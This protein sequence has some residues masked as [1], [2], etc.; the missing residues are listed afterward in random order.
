MYYKLYASNH[1]SSKTEIF[2]YKHKFS[3]L[4]IKF[5]FEITVFIDAFIVPSINSKFLRSE[6]EKHP[7]TITFT[8]I[9]EL[10]SIAKIT[11]FN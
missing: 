1:Y 3:E 6:A 10:S 4:R 7:H 5:S 11:D 9:R 8:F 2:F